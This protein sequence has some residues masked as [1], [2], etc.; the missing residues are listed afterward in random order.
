M[1]LETSRAG[2]VEVLLASDEEL[3]RLNLAFRGVDAATDVLSF[4]SAPLPGL[5]RADHG[6]IAI[7]LSFAQRQARRREVRIEDEAAM[8]AIHGGLH[9]L[10]WD[11]RTEKQR[12]EMVRKMNAV[13]ERAGIPTE[14]DWASEPREAPR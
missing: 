4:P 2:R 11:D 14:R 13:A 3:R 12:E 9:L 7:A 8:L 10:G 1:D 5:R 6:Q